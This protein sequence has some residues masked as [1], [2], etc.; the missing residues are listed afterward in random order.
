MAI[1]GIFWPISSNMDIQKKKVFGMGRLGGATTPEHFF[2]GR[3]AEA[4]G[5][6]FF[7]FFVGCQQHTHTQKLKKNTNTP[8][9]EAGEVHAPGS[10][11]FFTS[12]ALMVSMRGCLCVSH[13]QLPVSLLDIWP[14]CPVL[15]IFC[16]YWLRHMYG[17]GLILILILILIFFLILVKITYE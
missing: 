15:P 17:F 11:N 16:E 13:L 10:P 9:S 1:S 2:V 6:H 8:T 14:Y 4:G 3:F 5:H 7:G 12:T